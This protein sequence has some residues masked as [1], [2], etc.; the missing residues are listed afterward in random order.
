MDENDTLTILNL[1]ETTQELPS[2]NLL[3]IYGQVIAEIFETEATIAPPFT[4]KPL[5]HCEQQIQRKLSLAHKF[6]AL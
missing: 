4:D 1:I 5:E 6:R 3:F 2:P